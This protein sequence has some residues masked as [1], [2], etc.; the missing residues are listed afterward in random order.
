MTSSTFHHESELARSLSNNQEHAVATAP[1]TQSAPEVAVSVTVPADARLAVLR[2]VVDFAAANG[3]VRVGLDLELVRLLLLALLLEVVRLLTLRPVALAAALDKL[4]DGQLPPDVLAVIRT[5]VRDALA[6]CAELPAERREY[7]TGLLPATAAALGA[8]AEPRITGI[9]ATAEGYDLALTA[10][11]GAAFAVSVTLPEHLFASVVEGVLASAALVAAAPSHS[12]ARGLV[13]NL[14]NGY[15][16]GELSDAVS[17]VITAALH[18]SPELSKTHKNAFMGLPSVQR[19][20]DRF[21][22]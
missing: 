16:I 19:L 9:A 22:A 14:A 12:E 5:M 8:N 10:A 7:A 11:N 20:V 2:L 13:R 3:P 15:A 17:F 21:A 18:A 1:L 4:A 6:R